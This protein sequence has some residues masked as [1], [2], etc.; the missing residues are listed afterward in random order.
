MQE[1]VEL[2]VVV[3]VSLPICKRLIPVAPAHLPAEEIDGLVIRHL[4]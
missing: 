1:V 4:E 2:E 3:R